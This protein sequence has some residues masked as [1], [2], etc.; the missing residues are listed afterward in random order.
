MLR[1]LHPILLGPILLIYGA[2]W[3]FL[4][5]ASAGD[6]PKPPKFMHLP[7][8]VGAHYPLEFDV[9]IEPHADIRWITVEAW[10]AEPM[11]SLF[12]DLA[13]DA[14]MPA[15]YQVGQLISRGSSQ[16]VTELMTHQRTFRFVWK[17]GL[18][19]GLYFLI[20]RLASANFKP[21]KEAKKLLRVV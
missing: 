8:I 10:T 16:P 1:A 6:V 9:W 12:A 18:D 14:D 17:Q 15:L 4:S 13:P 21:M 5:M 3:F 11:S 2:L 20:C 7:G 19:E